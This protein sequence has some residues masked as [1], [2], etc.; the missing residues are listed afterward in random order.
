GDVRQVRLDPYWTRI[1]PPTR[2][3]NLIGLESRGVKVE[4][5]GFVS[6]KVR[7]QVAQELRREL[8][9]TSVLDTPH[10]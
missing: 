1:D 10:R 9:G 5:G 8:A 7:R 4:V 3:H 6:E 2:R